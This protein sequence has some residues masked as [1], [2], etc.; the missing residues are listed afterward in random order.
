MASFFQELKRRN[1]FK[2]AATYFVVAWLVIEVTATVLPIFE[3]P[4]WIVQVITLIIILAFPFALLFSWAYDLTPDGL[5]RTEALDPNDR[6][7]AESRSARKRNTTRVEYAVIG[8]L[9][10]A[11]VAVLTNRYV[12][13][14][15]YATR[16]AE[17]LIA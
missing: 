1:V 3:A 13:H 9:F 2:V 7:A 5:E 12:F 16:R 14:N 6:D 17:A 4:E 8:A 10:L 11:L 15:D